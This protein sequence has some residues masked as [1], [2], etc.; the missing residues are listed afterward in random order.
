MLAGSLGL[1]NFV[2]IDQEQQHKH[3]HHRRCEDSGSPW[4]LKKNAGVE[5]LND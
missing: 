2:G 4:Q 1:P 3:R 5:G